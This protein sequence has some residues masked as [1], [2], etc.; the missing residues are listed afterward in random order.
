MSCS[1]V[2]ARGCCD[3]LIK[4]K[5]DIGPWEQI[6]LRRI[7]MVAAKSAR[8]QDHGNGNLK[9]HQELTQIR[10]ADNLPTGENCKTFSF[11][12]R[13]GID[14]GLSTNSLICVE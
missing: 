2:W 12:L 8:C 6:F 4:D 5:S 7:S 3:D 14:A 10:A 13:G 9:E 1:P 11:H